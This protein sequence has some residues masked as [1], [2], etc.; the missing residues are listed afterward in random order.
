MKKEKSEPSYE[1][2]CKKCGR[3]FQTHLDTFWAQK[4]KLECTH[5]GNVAYYAPGDAKVSS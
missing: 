5:C 3:K 1:V 4:G 2:T